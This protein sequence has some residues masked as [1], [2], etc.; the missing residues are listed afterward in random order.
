VPKT[1]RKPYRVVDPADLDARGGPRQLF[2]A[3][4]AAGFIVEVRSP[5]KPEGVVAVGGV[6]DIGDGAGLAFVA[7]WV[8]GK[9]I[10]CTLYGERDEGYETVPAPKTV[11]SGR[12]QD[13]R[14]R[15]TGYTSGTRLV[16]RGG[17]RGISLGVNDLKARMAAL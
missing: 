14:E 6:R 17:P 1:K 13:R 10:G 11:V 5:R 8:D 2:N 12:G 7:T 16:Y 4:R 9:S 15:M 3:A